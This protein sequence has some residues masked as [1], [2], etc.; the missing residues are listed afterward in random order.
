[1]IMDKVRSIDITT[2]S[3]LYRKKIAHYTW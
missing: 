1:L 3:I 2:P